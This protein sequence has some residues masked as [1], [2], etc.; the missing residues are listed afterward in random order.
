MNKTRQEAKHVM[1]NIQVNEV[2]SVLFDSLQ[3]DMKEAQS[4]FGSFSTGNLNDK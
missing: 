3:K 1:R 4:A 2:H